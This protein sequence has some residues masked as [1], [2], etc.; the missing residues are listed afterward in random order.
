MN[1]YDKFYKILLE[2]EGGWVYDTKDSGGETYKGISRVYNPKWDGW[3]IID[4]YK[5]TH[6]LVKGSV[7]KDDALDELIKLFYKKNYYSPLG[8]DAFTDE[9]LALSLFDFGV[10]AGVKPAIKLLQEVLGITEDGIAG[11]M[12]I[13]EANS[14]PSM[15]QRYNEARI[16]AYKQMKTFYKF[17]KGWVSRVNKLESK[18]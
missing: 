3:K 15:G 10:N 16:D 7:I 17:G 6:K 2:A 13:R 11:R 14:Q 8:V 18:L 5:K 12:T 9:L 4:E 1:R